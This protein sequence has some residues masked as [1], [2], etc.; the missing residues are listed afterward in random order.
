MQTIRNIIKS[1]LPHRVF[2]FFQP[3]YHYLLAY[4]GAVK[5]RHPS[6]EIVVIGVTGTKGK[7][8]TTELLAAILRADKKVVA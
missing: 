1:I 5:Y 3:Y 6:R 8:S 2:K 4:W 7:A